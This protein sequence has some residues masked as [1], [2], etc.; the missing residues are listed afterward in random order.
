[1]IRIVIPGAPRTKKTHPRIIKVGRFHKILPSEAYLEWFEQAMFRVPEIKA[2]ARRE[3]IELPLKGLVE[4]KAIF[5]CENLI[6]GDLNGYQQ[7][8][9]DWLQERKINMKSNPPKLARD[10]A[11]IITD[12]KMIASWDGSRV[13]IDRQDPRTEIEIRPFQEHLELVSGEVSI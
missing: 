11:G 10:G 7:G 8:L 12:D 13:R 5:Y 6:L 4:V 9:G 1:M 2:W 3:G